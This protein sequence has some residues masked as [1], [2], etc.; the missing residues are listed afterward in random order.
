MDDFLLEDSTIEAM[1]AEYE[2]TLPAHMKSALAVD[3]RKIAMGWEMLHA[4]CATALKSSADEC[5]YTLLFDT[6]ERL[7]SLYEA[8]FST[9]IKSAE[10]IPAKCE[11]LLIAIDLYL[12]LPTPENAVI[13]SVICSLVR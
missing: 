8:R 10:K 9:S 4:Y 3:E 11:V 5:T 12:T 2:K 13:L 7:C 6:V 1:N